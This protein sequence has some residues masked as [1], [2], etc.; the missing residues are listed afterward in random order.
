M[1]E[2]TSQK[3]QFLV[4]LKIGDS[5]GNKSNDCTKLYKKMT[6]TTRISMASPNP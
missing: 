2:V 3:E 4:M 6:I 1:N 5:S